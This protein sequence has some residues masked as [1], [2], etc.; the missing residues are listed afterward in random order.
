MGVSERVCE[1]GSRQNGSK[2]GSRRRPSVR[3]RK[4]I[5]TRTDD[6]R[7][8]REWA[9]WFGSICLSLSLFSSMGLWR[10]R[11]SSSPS[12]DSCSFHLSRERQR[13][14]E[15]EEEG[16]KADPIAVL[17]P[18][19]LRASPVDTR[20]RRRRSLLRHHKSK[21]PLFTERGSLG[22][23]GAKSDVDARRMSS[24]F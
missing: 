5:R 14:R 7:V 24:A 9:R 4:W 20:R 15:S 21:R 12:L 10:E 18:N 19:P 11:R 17:A 8:A 23:Q 16:R 3:L 13:R 22:R 2:E 6:H 1:R